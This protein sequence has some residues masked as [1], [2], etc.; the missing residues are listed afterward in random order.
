MAGGKDFISSCRSSMGFSL[1][2]TSTFSHAGEFQWILTFVI[3]VGKISLF[4]CLI[5]FHFCFLA[6]YVVL[7]V[8]NE[9]NETGA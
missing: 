5:G 8:K 1:L 9:I 6:L 2:I 4:V 7:I 3:W